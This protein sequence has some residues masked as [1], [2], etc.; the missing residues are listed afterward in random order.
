MAGPNSSKTLADGGCLTLFGLPFLGAGLFMAWLYFSG[1]VKWW[2]AQSWLEVPCWI[3]SAELK[4]SRGDDSTTYKAKATYRY[5]YAG[6]DYQGDRVS[7]GSGSDNVGD[8]QQKAHRELS[9]YAGGK[10]SGAERDP[11]RDTKKPFRCYVNPVNPSEAVIYRTLRWQVQAFYAVFALTFPAIGA[12]L[13]CATLMGM[14]MLK[15]ETALSEEHPEEPWKWKLDWAESSIPES[16]TFWSKALVF[17]TLWAA[18]IIF[19]LILAAAMSG[20]FQTDKM[21]WLLLI[22]VALWCIPAWITSKRIRHRMAVGKTRFELQESPAWPG[23]LLRGSIL[24]GKPLPSRG[25]VE[26][27]LSCEKRTTRRSGED[28]SII[29]EKIWNHQEIVPQDRV[30]RDFTGFRLPVG[31]ALPADAPESGARGDSAVEHVWK[32]ELKVPGTA[33]HSVFEV[34]VFHTGKSPVL[35]TNAVVPSISETASSDLPA[36]LAEQRIK[37]DFDHAGMPLSIICPPARHRSLLV[38]LV[39]FNLIWT[40]VAVVLLKQKAPLVF[41]IV[42]PCSAGVIWLTIFWQLLYKRTA[43]FTGSG[44]KLI[45]QLGPVSRG[46]VFEKSRITG[47]SHDTNMTS[48]N[49]SF[50]RVRLENVLGKKKTVADGINCSTTAE[51]LVQRLETWKRSV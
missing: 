6:R 34:P 24:L 38:F 16:A 31:F 41:Q 17:Y 48:N 27:G 43:T 13:V 49:T 28:K 25:S 9:L 2:G 8:F 40:A 36:L 47:F 29:K 50:Y 18:L 11:Q 33:V 14:R 10:P 46:E 3:E 32:L 19:P 12:G 15:K 42:W 26:L 1:Y 30:T 4:T 22:F 23:G 20:S 44:L 5:E 7:F 51:A 39:I 45:H 37:T 35:A 21:A